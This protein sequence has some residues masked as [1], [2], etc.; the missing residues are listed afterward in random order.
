MKV[1]RNN[2]KHTIRDDLFLN[3]HATDKDLKFLPRLTGV[4]DKFI[5]TRLPEIKKL[6]KEL[7][8]DNKPEILIPM[9]IERLKY[10]EEKILIA[11]LL[12]LEKNIDKQ[13][14]LLDMFLPY[15][16]SW[17]I[18]DSMVCRLRPM[19]KNTGQFI[20]RR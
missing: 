19:I 16:N 11:D 10:H 12:G 5:G 14:E 6:A 13:V 18:S 15:I 7:I 4:E 17:D 1:T 2:Y 3:S 20:K 8:K 9:I